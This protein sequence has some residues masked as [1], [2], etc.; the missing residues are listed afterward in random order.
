MINRRVFL[1][2]AAVLAAQAAGCA[3]LPI[4]TST[5]SQSLSQTFELSPILSAPPAAPREFRGVW[6]ATVANIDWPSRPGLTPEAQRNEALKLL[7]TAYSMRLNAV[8]LQIRPSA[9]ALYSSNLE[10]WSEYLTGQQGKAPEPFY[11]P[12]TFWIDEAH[13]RG[14]ELHAWFNPFRARHPT[15]AGAL[16]EMHVSQRLPDAVKSYGDLLWLDP[17]HSRAAEHSLAVIADVTRRY[18]IDGVHIDDYFYPYPIEAKKIPAAE[19]AADG[20]GLTAGSAKVWEEFPD[21]PSW[22]AY[23]ASGG[24]LTRSDWRRENVNQFVSRL[25]SS[26]RAIKPW[27][28]VGISPFGIGRPDR[29]PAGIS[30]FSQYDQLYADAE[31][32]LEEGW[33]DYLAPQLYWPIQQSAQAFAV[34]HEYWLRQNPRQRHIWPGLYTSQVGAAKK[35]WPAEEIP[36]QISLARK[37]SPDAGHLHFSM[38]ALAQNR[39]NLTQQLTTE[40]YATAALI[41][42]TPWLGMPAP[43]APGLT[44]S[45]DRNQVAVRIADGVT[46]TRIAIWRRYGNQW[47]FAAQPAIQRMITL[48]PDPQL[49]AVSEIVVSLIN[50]TGIESPRTS[51]DTPIIGG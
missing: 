51:M 4:S 11:D 44:L 43:A 46:V 27:V 39:Q 10:P 13:R 18:D 26:V 25:Y 7:D 32:W 17:G 21:T 49:G 48:A 23:A 14:L 12:L 31:R 28:T 29:R 47:R 30:G 38:V 6:V 19:P 3:R 35:P 33:L 22:Q 41:P 34:L 50:R 1:I 9:D 45:A 8:V 15:S 37:Q 40:T 42:A 36:A 5:R 2:T 24:T 16:S 20:N